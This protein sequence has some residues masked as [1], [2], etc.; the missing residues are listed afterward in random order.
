MLIRTYIENFKSIRDKSEFNMLA[1]SYKRFPEHVYDGYNEMKILKNAAIYGSNAAG[2]TNF[3]LALE[4]LS[5]IVVNG[6]EDLLESLPYYPNKLC[7]TSLNAPTKFEIDFLHE[8]TEYSYGI[9]YKS[10]IILEEWLY[11]GVSQTPKKIFERSTNPENGKS[12]LVLN[13]LFSKDSKDEKIRHKI[14]EEDLRANEPFIFVGFNKSLKIIE[15]AYKWFDESL[16]FIFV[17]SRYGGLARFLSNYDWF[18]KDFLEILKTANLGIDSIEVEEISLDD[19]FGKEQENFKKQIRKRISKDRGFDLDST[20][21]GNCAYINNDNEAV[22]GKLMFYHTDLDGDLIEFDLSEESRGTKRILDIIPA[23]VYAAKTKTTYIIDEIES[24]IHPLLIRSILK[25]FMKANSKGSQCQLIF[26]THE[27][28]LLDL[29]LFRQDELWFA[30]R[31]K[32]I[33]T[34][35]YSLSDFK[36]RHDLDVKKGY[37][38]GK[39]GAIPYIKNLD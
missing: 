37:L 39:F 12:K 24:S 33:S 3:I 5:D 25:L 22:V 4:A 1:G 31:S 19:F 8:G 6:T 11:T 20:S 23:I 7:K 28:T 35:I 38:E 9:S 21:G 13:K 14:Y 36:V 32:K 2:K 17:H 10:D 34:N 27:S 18:K 26:T 29:E 16:S 30:E 15:E